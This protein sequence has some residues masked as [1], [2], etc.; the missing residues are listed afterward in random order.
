MKKIIAASGLAVIALA[1]GIA[2]AQ[3]GDRPDPNA[4]ATRAETITRANARFDQLDVD[5]DGKLT[6]QDRELGKAERANR[7]FAAMD[8][9]GN[10]QIS[11]AE[12]D[13]SRAKRAEG[14]KDRREAR[15]GGPDG[16]GMDGGP[17]GHRKG[18][19]GHRFGGGRAGMGAKLDTNGDG[20][21][22][23]QEFQATA[24]ARFEQA[25]ANK[26]G[27]VTPDERRAART[28]W[29]EAW[30]AKRGS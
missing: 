8:A 30:K 17:R 6:P 9:D 25:D 13:S 21:V 29:R 5:K 26:D 28:A 7:M 3:P 16:P 11:R 14:R 24:V 20:A 22:T 15:G 18:R 4:T 12:F 27:S 10:G 2:I 19:M 1:G 23:R